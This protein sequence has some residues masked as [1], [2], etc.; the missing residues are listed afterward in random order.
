MSLFSKLFKKPRNR[1]ESAALLQQQQE[2]LIFADNLAAWQEPLGPTIPFNPSQLR[3]IVFR[4]SDRGRQLLFDSASLQVVARLNGRLRHDNE[5]SV[6]KSTPPSRRPSGQLNGPPA[7]QHTQAPVGLEVSLAVPTSVPAS[8]IPSAPANVVGSSLND[9]RRAVAQTM[10]QSRSDVKMFGEMI[11]GSIPITVRS[12]ITKVHEMRNPCQL[13]LTKVY[14][15]YLPNNKNGHADEDDLQNGSRVSE[16]RS[17]VSSDESM[18]IHISP[19]YSHMFVPD[20]INRRSA[21]TMASP[22]M[23]PSQSTSSLSSL[24]FSPPKSLSVFAG[25]SSFKRRIRHNRSTSIDNG[26]KMLLNMDQEEEFSDGHIR[27]KKSVVAVAC[28]VYVSEKEDSQRELFHEFFFTH[29][30]LF[31]YSLNIFKARLEVALSGKTNFSEI[32]SA[33][34]GDFIREVTSLVTAPRLPLPMWLVIATE[35][36]PD[37]SFVTFLRL[38]LVDSLS[39]LIARH[40]VKETQFFVSRLVTA[41]LTGHIG[42]VSTVTPSNSQTNHYKMK[43]EPG[44]AQPLAKSHPYNPLWAQLGDLL[45]ICGTPPRL[46]KT[47]LVS[48]NSNLLNAYLHV[49]SYFIRTSD[50][51][52]HKFE[53]VNSPLAGVPHQPPLG[54][55]NGSL[56]PN[57]AVTEF[58][59][60]GR[61]RRHQSGGSGTWFN[62]AKRISG[63]GPRSRLASF[64]ESHVVP[65]LSRQDTSNSSTAVDQARDAVDGVFKKHPILETFPII[66]SSKSFSTLSGVGTSRSSITEENS[67]FWETSTDDSKLQTVCEVASHLLSQQVNGRDT[68]RIRPRRWTMLDQQQ[69]VTESREFV[70][71]LPRPPKHTVISINKD[72]ATTEK[73]VWLHVQEAFITRYQAVEMQPKFMDQAYENAAS[74]A[75]SLLV[76]PQVEYTPHFALQGCQSVDMAKVAQDLQVAAENCLTDEPCTEACAIVADLD[77]FTVKVISRTARKCPRGVLI[78]PKA[79]TPDSE[80]HREVDCHASNFVVLMLEAV[81]H[82]WHLRTTPEFCLMHMEDRLQEMYV[83]S[84]TMASFIRHQ[85]TID[86]KE[87]M[88]LLGLEMS[89]FPLLF[90]VASTHSADIVADL[91]MS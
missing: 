35:K 5:A 43:H 65:R 55:E 12:V 26:V 32:V 9:Q 14:P 66:S 34:F 38:R 22:A 23:T 50:V 68:D 25:G 56:V 1:D 57:A 48:Q 2:A 42:W 17:S 6:V 33:A 61:T 53:P 54:K 4:E 71:S 85:N 64:D 51:V 90:A 31:E 58:P 80:S 78:Q 81:A 21:S 77:K 8:V 15:V 24:P 40:D 18:S 41:I 89:D 59:E 29:T 13:M 44:W 30:P 62:K 60:N 87:M 49:M 20:R 10:R 11:F 73:P 72:A 36:H 67:V 63:P 16:T 70:R 52:Y 47:I 45:G 7:L 91:D 79:Q 39:K 19:P 3:I 88:D 75:T 86:T 46:T 69:D 83:Q 82:L 27:T 74:F 76:A 28:L 84:Q 37:E